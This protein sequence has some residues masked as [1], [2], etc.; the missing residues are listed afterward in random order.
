MLALRP[1]HNIME[2]I[3]VRTSSLEVGCSTRPRWKRSK[4]LP[5]A[6]QVRQSRAQSVSIILSLQKLVL[7]YIERVTTKPVEPLGPVSAQP[8]RLS[9]VF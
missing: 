8:D 4:R 1:L 5:P 6:V 7:M 9:G 3:L 2:H